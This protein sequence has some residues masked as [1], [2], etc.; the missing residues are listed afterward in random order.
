[1]ENEENQHSFVQTSRMTINMYNES[2]EV[3]KGMLKEDIISKLI[4]I[5]RKEH[6]EKVKENIQKQLKEF[7]DSKNKNFEK[8]QE[9][10][11]ELREDFNKLQK[12]AK[13]IAKKRY[14]K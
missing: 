6:D 5:L 8:I 10:L 14:M 7:Q 4:E 11:N 9:Q 1:V 2:N 3:C 13:E 12:E